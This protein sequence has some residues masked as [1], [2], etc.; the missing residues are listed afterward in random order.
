M[1]E[2]RCWAGRVMRVRGG[3]GREPPYKPGKCEALWGLMRDAFSPKPSPAIMTA[4]A[5]LG[6]GPVPYGSPHHYLSTVLDRRSSGRFRAAQ[7]AMTSYSSHTCC[8]GLK[9]VRSKMRETTG[10]QY[11]DSGQNEFSEKERR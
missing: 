3:K 6:M 9:R 2:R 4:V 1:R 8:L 5:S 11:S 7:V 10:G